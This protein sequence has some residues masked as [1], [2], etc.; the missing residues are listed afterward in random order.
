MPDV[1]VRA[2]L[3]AGLLLASLASV[4]GQATEQAPLKGVGE[5]EVPAWFKMS[6]LDL[7][8]DVAEA[9][10]EGKQLGVFFH[11]KGC[12]YCEKLFDY[13]FSQ[14][15]IRAY[16]TEHYHA[17]DINMWGDREVVDVDGEV[18]TEKAFAEKH[19]VWFTPTLLLFD[20]HGA[21]MLRVNGYYPPERFK[22]ALEYAATGGEATF[23]EYL[24]R[25]SVA[26][27]RE[28]LTAQP[29]FAE[30]PHVLDAVEGP[31][32][33]LFEQ[34][35][36]RACRELH[37]GPLS[38]PQTRDMLS[39]VHVVQLDRWSREDLVTPSGERMT[40][41]AFADRLGVEYLPTAVFYDDGREVI[42]M[43]AMF[44]SFHV[45]SM[46]DYTVSG[47]YTGND[48]FQR[49]LSKRADALREQGITVD[50]WQ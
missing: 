12:P 44:K 13:N 2:G 49:W 7:A 26:E 10:A 41:R 50:L 29:F 35:A 27:P 42:R 19:R 39:E 28:R 22:A 48:N 16:F 30:P 36:C 33:L 5:F 38:A 40:A 9:R 37:A 23:A 17:V 32:M 11:Q 15:A 47:A 4:S 6:F 20:E 14:R 8:E 1:R 25:I 24:A 3:C 31:L 34:R 18:L 46:I 43:E 45:Q 21:V